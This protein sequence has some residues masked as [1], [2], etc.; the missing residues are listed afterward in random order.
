MLSQ[1]GDSCANMLSKRYADMLSQFDFILW[2]L[3][4]DPDVSSTWIASVILLH[5]QEAA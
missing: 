5:K 3:E 2:S 1:F 4:Y